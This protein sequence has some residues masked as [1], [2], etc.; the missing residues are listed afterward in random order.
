MR[1]TTEHRTPLGHE[2]VVHTYLTAR[3]M[4]EIGGAY[5]KHM[6]ITMGAPE[7]GAATPT[8]KVEMGDAAAAERD[9]QDLL[10]RHGV[11]TYAGSADNVLDRL[12]DGPDGE[13]QF[14]LALV[15]PLKENPGKPK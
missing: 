6:K 10:I 9:E 15:K 12:L 1:E 3:E 2:V 14:V 13:F 5:Q 7:P 11:A 4:R 8:P